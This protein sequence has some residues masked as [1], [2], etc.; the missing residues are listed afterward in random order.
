M[1]HLWSSIHK[2]LA[3]TTKWAQNITQQTEG[4]A[5]RLQQIR[6]S[7]PGLR[8][9]ATWAAR[10]AVNFLVGFHS[11]YTPNGRE[12]SFT[13]CKITFAFACGHTQVKYPR[14]GAAGRYWER[15]PFVYSTHKELF[16]SLLTFNLHSLFF[17]PKNSLCNSRGNSKHTELLL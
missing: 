9:Y 11:F 6:W 16:W 8:V 7:L 10:S 5:L 1:P 2:P 4:E 13:F 15:K 17:P 12:R 14:V 3:K